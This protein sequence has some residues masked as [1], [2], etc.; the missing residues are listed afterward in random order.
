MPSD[1]SY[2]QTK[3]IKRI[4]VI[5][6]APFKELI[7][8]FA[9]H[10]HVPVLNVIYDIAPA[11]RP[12]LSIIFEKQEDALKFRTGAL[13]NFNKVDQKR[14]AEQ[15]AVILS[16]HHRH[17]FKLVGLFVIFVAFE[18]VARIEANESVTEKELEN[19]KNTIANK[20]LWKIS[21]LFDSVTFL[22]Y[23]DEQARNCEKNGLKTA[24]SLEYSRLVEPYDEFGYLRQRGVTVTFDSKENFDKNYQSNWYY[25][26]K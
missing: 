2:Q 16:A 11:N 5:P 15:F 4:G 10:Y 6:P 21:R 26:Y 24:Y 8:W 25:F 18:P 3:R 9:F 17:Q 13:G 19:L 23:T 20:D 22:F 7:D 12:R 14:V 1:D